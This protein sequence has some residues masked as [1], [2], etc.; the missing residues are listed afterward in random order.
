MA[1]DILFL[2]EC[3]KFIIS[4]SHFRYQCHLQGVTCFHRLQ[5]GGNSRFVCPTKIP[6]Q[7]QFPRESQFGSV[8][9]IGFWVITSVI[10]AFFLSIN[11]GSYFRELIG[12]G[13]PFRSD[14]LLNLRNS[15][16]HVFII[17]ESDGNQTLQSRIDIQALP[18][19]AVY[20]SCIRSCHNL[21]RKIQFRTSVLLADLAGRKSQ[22]KG[23]D[24]EYIDISF[25]CNYLLIVR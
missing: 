15:D 13:D 19:D 6:P 3:T 20:R 8:F 9:R 12:K 24:Y 23:Q 14:H 4:S 16:L 22:R 5:I 1:Y 17:I 18:R 25:H 7:V 21:F 2:I 11:P 10:Q